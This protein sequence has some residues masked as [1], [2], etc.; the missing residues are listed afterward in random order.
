MGT[1]NIILRP[2]KREDA[3][4]LHEL[5]TASVRTLCKN[6]YSEEVIDGW[7][8]NRTPSGYHKPIDSH[9]LFVAELEGQIVGFGEAVPGR[10][11]AV[12]ADPGH[13][14][15][16]IGTMILAHAVDMARKD[17]KGPIRLESTLNARDFYSHA[18][19]REIEQSTVHRNHVDV[20][21]VIMEY[22]NN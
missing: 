5:H 21:V 22:E 17:H 4:R 3:D 9:A 12:Y 20:P 11:V 2:S 13:I 1:K 16:G 10:I 14:H 7:L 8:L 6:C 18:G 19:F 15:Q